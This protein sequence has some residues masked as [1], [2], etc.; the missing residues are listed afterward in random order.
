LR[1]RLSFAEDSSVTDP[2]IPGAPGDRRSLFRNALRH[3]AGSVVERTEKRVVQ[4]RYGRPPGALPEIGFLAACTRCGACAEACPPRAILTV[5]TDGGLAAGTP[6]LDAAVQPCTVCPDMPCA[7]ACPTGALVP[8]AEKWSG[9]RL[10]ELAFHP[11]RCVTFH[12]TP[13]GV[14]AEAC[15]VGE[16]A[17]AMDAAGHPVLRREGCVGCGICVRSCITTPSSFELTFAEG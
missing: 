12:G 2:S 5:R 14:C 16:S 17:L 13:C 8:P 3:W 6:Y 9:Y 11:E 15:P 1:A 7:V 10:A 4:K